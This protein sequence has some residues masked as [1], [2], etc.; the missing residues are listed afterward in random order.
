MVRKVLLSIG[1]SSLVHSYKVENYTFDRYNQQIEELNDKLKKTTSPEEIKLIRDEKL[2]AIGYLFQVM[3]WLHPFIDGQG[4]TDLVLLSKLLTEQG[5]N[6]AIL[7]E[8]YVSS[9]STLEEWK[10]YLISGMKHWQNERSP[11]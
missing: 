11:S 5:F 8:P 3:Q 9:W 6:P 4:R 10:N 2:T 7:E 1:Y